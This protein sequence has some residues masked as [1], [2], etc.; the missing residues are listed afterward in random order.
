MTPK[1]KALELINMF[2]C[3]G[4]QQRMEGIACAEIA[5]DEILKIADPDVFMCKSYT[6]DFYSDQE[7]FIA[8]KKEIQ[9]L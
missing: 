6:G 7:Y 3:V 1:E 9:K 8:V 4:L 5:V 2:S